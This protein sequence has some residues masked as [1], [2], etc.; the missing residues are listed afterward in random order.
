MSECSRISCF[1]GILPEVQPRISNFHVPYA[2]QKTFKGPL[3]LPKPNDL[4]KAFILCP[5]QEGPQQTVQQKRFWKT[6][7]FCLSSVHIA[8]ATRSTSSKVAYEYKKKNI[9]GKTFYLARIEAQ[10][11]AIEQP[12]KRICECT[13]GKGLSV[14]SIVLNRLHRKGI[15]TGTFNVAICDFRVVEKEKG[16]GFLHTMYEFDNTKNTPST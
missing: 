14:A 9:Q 7:N 8:L 5:I 13:L 4:K 16:V 10:W 12:W 2:A 15:W 11:F 3:V 6:K 1:K